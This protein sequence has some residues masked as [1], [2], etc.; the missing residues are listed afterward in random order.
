MRADN[1]TKFWNNSGFGGTTIVDNEVTFDDNYTVPAEQQEPTYRSNYN[2][3][4]W[5]HRNTKKDVDILEL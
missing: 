5:G 2:N 1:A 4:R 3:E